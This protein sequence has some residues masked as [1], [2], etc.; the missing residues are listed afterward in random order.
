[1]TVPECKLGEHSAEF[2]QI[3]EE[4]LELVEQG[5]PPAIEEY[6]QQ[7]RLSLDSSCWPRRDGDRL[8]GDSRISGS[9]S[10]TQSTAASA[11]SNTWESLLE[12]ETIYHG[13]LEKCRKTW[14]GFVHMSQY[15]VDHTCPKC[16]SGLMRVHTR[17]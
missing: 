6:A 13:E 14:N 7:Y 16:Y 5:N 3:V 9:Q 4:Y 15:V 1:M 8:R 12:I 11:V 2:N 10:G 17:G